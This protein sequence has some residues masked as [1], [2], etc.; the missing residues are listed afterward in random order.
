MKAPAPPMGEMTTADPSSR[1]GSDD[2]KHPV[3]KK[4]GL[5]E[6]ALPALPTP[7][8]DRA[9][10]AAPQISCGKETD[11]A[12]AE[13][14]MEVEAGSWRR[15]S[16]EL[17]RSEMAPPPPSAADQSQHRTPGDSGRAPELSLEELSISSRQQQQQQ[18]YA[19]TVKVT[20][21]GHLVAATGGDQAA[22]AAARRPC[23]KRKLLED[24]ESGKTLLMDAYRVWQQGQKVMT[25]DLGRIEKIMS[26]T[27]MLIKQV[28]VLGDLSLGGGVW[29]G[30]R[31]LNQCGAGLGWAGPPTTGTYC[32]TAVMLSVL[33]LL[34]R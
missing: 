25:Y 32:K 17:Q 34:C 15:P 8:A 33:L 13:E 9:V 19:S 1:P 3:P 31:G 30:G 18:L 16:A 2:S 7:P 12:R 10:K 27:Y 14:A 11:G 29:R 5:A 24:V 26:E 23:R 21:Q 4:P 22:L 6:A 20:G 28:I